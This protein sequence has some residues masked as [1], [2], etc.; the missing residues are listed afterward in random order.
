MSNTHQQ[1]DVNPCGCSD[2]H[3]N[4]P[5]C[6]PLANP[7]VPYQCRE[8]RKYQPQK[9]VIRG[10]MF[11]ALDLP[12]HDIVNET[13]LPKSLLHQIQTLSFA[14]TELGLYLDTHADDEEALDLFNRYKELY[15]ELLA[16]YQSKHGPMIQLDA[17]CDGK[18]D[19]LQ[20]PWPWDYKGRED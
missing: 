18:Y 12:L 9:G 20:D 3:G 8:A 15:G 1:P 2:Y 17:G 16:E 14:T 6:A 5:S 19:W 10:T 7:Y 13:E 4:L 11:P